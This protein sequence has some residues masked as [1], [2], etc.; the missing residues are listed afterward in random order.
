MNQFNVKIADVVFRVCANYQE[1]MDYFSDFLTNEMEQERITIYYEE[2]T[3]LK[4]EY[5]DYTDEMCER[6]ALKYK[7]DSILVDY[8]TFALHASALSYKGNAYLFT[9][10]SG[11][12][13]S[14]H[15]RLW[16]EAFRDEVIMINDDRPY[17]KLDND[18]VYAYSHPQSGKH[19]IYTNISCPV[20]VIG[21]IVRDSSNYIRHVPRSEFFPF[22]VQQSFTMDKPSMTAKIVS[23]IRKMSMHIWFFEIHCCLDNKAAVEICSQID[24]FISSK[25][26]KNR[27]C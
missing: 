1:T 11:I 17:L 27:I 24:T 4:T 18:T 12:G 22:F 3:A 8:Q 16:R 13:K 25:Q 26:Q 9:G 6:A 10:L 23:N 20:R 5:P 2:I 19:N 7:M 21:K 15:S 14:T